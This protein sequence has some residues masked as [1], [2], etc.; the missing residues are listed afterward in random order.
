MVFING[1]Y[2]SYEG[3]IALLKS[4]T[5]TLSEYA[6]RVFHDINNNDPTKA[7]TLASDLLALPIARGLTIKGY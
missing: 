6:P 4:S 3:Y 2:T 1:T 7:A 5:E